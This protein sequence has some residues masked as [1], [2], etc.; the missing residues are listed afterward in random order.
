MLARMESESCDQVHWG[1]AAQEND[2][3]GALFLMG[4]KG[5]K[6]AGG[7]DLPWMVGEEERRKEGRNALIFTDTQVNN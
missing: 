6:V 7:P 4:D 5:R 1:S 2:N 3:G